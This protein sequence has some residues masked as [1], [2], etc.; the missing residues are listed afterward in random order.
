MNVVDFPARGEACSVLQARD[1]SALPGIK[2]PGVAAA[3]WQRD[4]APEFANWISGLPPEKLPKLRSLVGV[5]A[6]EGCIQA[7][8]S[9]AGTP[10]GPERDMLAGD[11][12]ALGFLMSEIMETPLLHVRLEVVTTNACRRFHVDNM[13]ARLLCTYLGAGTQLAQPGAEA[14]PL[15]VSSGSAVLLRGRRWP[16]K[17]Q[18]ALLHRS[19]PIEG[20][21]ETRFL[22]VIDPAM[23]H[24]PQ[25]TLH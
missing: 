17:E 15:S 11:I 2:Q 5:D 23:D 9:L 12:A 18:T 19:P 13:T 20:T 10:A 4:P 6:L 8:C 25:E 14:A 24:E 7:A 16:G 21:G 22:A 1:A 3:I